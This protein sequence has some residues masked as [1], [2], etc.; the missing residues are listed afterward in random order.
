MTA[1]AELRKIHAEIGKLYDKARKMQAALHAE[2]VAKAEKMIGKC[3]KDRLNNVFYRIETIRVPDDN[4]GTLFFGPSVSENKLYISTWFK[5]GE[6][7]AAKA[8]DFEKALAA[9][10]K[11]MP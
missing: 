5:P 4:E 1:K 6:L 3:F 7:V 2:Y 8:A 9:F 11:A 10:K